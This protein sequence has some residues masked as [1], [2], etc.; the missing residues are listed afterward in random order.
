MDNVLLLLILLVNALLLAGFFVLTAKFRAIF[1]EILSF[2]TPVGEGQPSPAAQV[3]DAMASLFI[4]K[5]KFT[6]MGLASVEAKQAKRLEGEIALANAS[7]KSPLLGL[8]MT[9][10]PSLRKA[11][12]KHSFLL[13][14]ALKKAA[15]LGGSRGSPP[16]AGGNGVDDFADRLRRYG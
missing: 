15:E 5:L 8:A 6:L 2:I 10:F 3:Y 7:E 12:G 4:E 1:H 9:M 14:L 11:A 13:D 16:P